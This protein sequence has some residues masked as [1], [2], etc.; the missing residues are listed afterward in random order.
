MLSLALEA[1]QEF[2]SLFAVKKYQSI[3]DLLNN[4]KA[5]HAKRGRR[6]VF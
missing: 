3:D 4:E 2:S 1:S 5:S 6:N